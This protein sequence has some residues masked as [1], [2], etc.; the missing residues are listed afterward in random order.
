MLIADLRAVC[1]VQSAFSRL[2]EQIHDFVYLA[3][4]RNQ[5]LQ[6]PLQIGRSQS[7]LGKVS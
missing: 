7:D 4:K 3:Q 2:Q 6:V 5:D 1:I